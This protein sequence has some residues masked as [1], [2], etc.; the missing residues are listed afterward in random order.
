VKNI[1][2][3]RQQIFQALDD[4]INRR[5]KLVAEGQSLGDV[6]KCQLCLVMNPYIGCD[7]CPLKLYQSGVYKSGC[8]NGSLYDN[9]IMFSPEDPCYREYV[10]AMVYLLEQIRGHYFP[11][12]VVHDPEIIWMPEHVSH[13]WGDEDEEE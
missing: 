4:S 11:N 2:V 8:G 10:N 9:I 12:G 7:A 13:P 1:G 3:T 5:W 6:Q